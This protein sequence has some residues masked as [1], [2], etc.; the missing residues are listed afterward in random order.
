MWRGTARPDVD[1]VEE[2]E[3]DHEPFERDPVEPLLLGQGRADD[4]E[5]DA[6]DEGDRA[7]DGLEALR[8]RGA[9]EREQGQ[10]VPGRSLDAR[11]V[12]DVDPVPDRDELLRAA[13]GTSADRR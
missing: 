8:R 3:V 10:L 7:D 6:R 1:A 4:E 11:Q 5:L 2:A 9:A 12:G 13:T